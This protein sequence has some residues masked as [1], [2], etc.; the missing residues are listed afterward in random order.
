MKNVYILISAILL[1]SL[2]SFARAQENFRQMLDSLYQTQNRIYNPEF[3]KN[4]QKFLAKQ[5][6]FKAGE[7]AVEKAFSDFAGRKD[8]HKKEYYK[9]LADYLLENMGAGISKDDISFMDGEEFAQ[10]F[11]NYEF[12]RRN[13]TEEY[14]TNDVK[15]RVLL[16]MNKGNWPVWTIST[17]APKNVGV[18]IEDTIELDKWAIGVRFDDKEKV[19]K[20]LL[21]SEDISP[22]NIDEVLKPKMKKAGFKF[23]SYDAR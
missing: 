9:V 2:C 21:V 23:N 16:V 3:I 4:N 19:S 18:L 1:C 11:K 7:Q 17:A 13:K 14:Q 22:A 8:E 12:Y 10:K 15:D 20:N 5:P 6:E